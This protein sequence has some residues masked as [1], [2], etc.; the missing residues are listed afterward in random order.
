MPRPC[1]HSSLGSIPILFG[2]FGVAGSSCVCHCS[3][4][5]RYLNLHPSI[6]TALFG[7]LGLPGAAVGLGGVRLHSSGDK[8]LGQLGPQSF[9][10]AP[11]PARGG[12]QTINS[13]LA[14]EAE[15]PGDR[16]SGAGRVRGSPPVLYI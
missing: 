2:K 4:C 11:N 12:S 9:P 14:V 13:M 1:I 16:P 8:G 10:A 3:C 7:P 6:L 15:D 5:T